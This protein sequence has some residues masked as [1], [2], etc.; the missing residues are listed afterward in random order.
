MQSH[1][2][3]ATVFDTAS[4]SADALKRH[5]TADHSRKSTPANSVEAPTGSGD[6]V[7]NDGRLFGSMKHSVSARLTSVGRDMSPRNKNG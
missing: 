3:R 4:K 2:L 1:D 6:I 7:D 5:R